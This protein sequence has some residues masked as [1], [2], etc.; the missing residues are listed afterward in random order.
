[1]LNELPYICREMSFE[2]SDELVDGAYLVGYASVMA[3]IKTYM[4][5]VTMDTN[6]QTVYMGVS[7]NVAIYLEYR[8]MFLEN[9]VIHYAL[10][11]DMRV[12]KEFAWKSRDNYICSIW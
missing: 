10:N 5:K 9:C 1:M 2:I 4:N 11:I 7:G 12:V 6:V 8:V 3:Y